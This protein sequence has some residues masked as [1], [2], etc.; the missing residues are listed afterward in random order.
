MYKYYH[1]QML[2][3]DVEGYI[4]STCEQMT[5]SSQFCV[6]KIGDYGNIRI[7]ENNSMPGCYLQWTSNGFDCLVGVMQKIIKYAHSIPA[8]SLHTQP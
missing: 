7:F 1:T 2:S 3:C 4:S 5:S 8:S 6:H